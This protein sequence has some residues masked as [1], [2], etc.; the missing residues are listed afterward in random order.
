MTLNRLLLLAGVAVLLGGSLTKVFAV[1]FGSDAER[2]TFDGQ[3][4][5]ANAKKVLAL[6]STKYTKE[7]RC[8]VPKTGV[9]VIKKAINEQSCVFA[10]LRNVLFAGQNVVEARYRFINGRFEQLDLEI[11]EVT[12]E[13]KQALLQ[14]LTTSLNVELEVE[15]PI[16]RWSGK[17]DTAMLVRQGNYKFRMANRVYLPDDVD[18]NK[19]TLR[20]Y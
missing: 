19:L 13:S 2:F 14:T 3:R 5:G 8:T 11:E 1:K 10:S 7:P 17:N 18:Y 16:N 4:L 9:V 12:V 20:K 15:G 6:A